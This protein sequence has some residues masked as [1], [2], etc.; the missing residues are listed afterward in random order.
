MFAL[1]S[2]F[3]MGIAPCGFTS[4]WT[5]YAPIVLFLETFTAP[6]H[7]SLKQ[8]GLHMGTIWRAVE[9][10]K[11]LPVLPSPWQWCLTLIWVMV[12]IQIDFS[13]PIYKGI[14]KS[15]QD[16]TTLSY[17]KI[18]SFKKN[19]CHKLKVTPWG[20]SPVIFQFNRK[21]NWYLKS[22]D[23]SELIFWVKPA[24]FPFVIAREKNT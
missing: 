12:G 18:E 9:Y 11:L 6:Q 10:S 24:S 4:F 15:T 21:I 23:K 20:R 3:W 7:N 17:D 8:R 16:N 2:C 14:F 1:L 22:L 19:P 5:S 13:P